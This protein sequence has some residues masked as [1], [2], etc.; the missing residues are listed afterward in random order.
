MTPTDQF[1]DITPP[2]NVA[3]PNQVQTSSTGAAAGVAVFTSLDA[4]HQPV[5]KV[6]VCFE[7]TTE[8]AF[9]RFGPATSSGT[10]AVNGAIVKAGQPGRVFCLD[11]VKHAFMDVY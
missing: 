8:D 7:A 4:A 1:F 9:V 5:G 3:G 2:S 11:P 6:M 10:T